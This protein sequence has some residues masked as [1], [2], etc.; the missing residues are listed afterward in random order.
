MINYRKSFT[1][2]KTTD[3]WL[4]KQPIWHDSDV[5]KF[6]AIA[7]VIGFSLGFLFGYSAG[8]PDLSGITHT[9]IKG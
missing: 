7:V 1:G 5:V 2:H 8:L 6:V 9:G 4:S 3:E